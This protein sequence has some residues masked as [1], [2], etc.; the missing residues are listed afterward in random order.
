MSALSRAKGKAEVI[1]LILSPV[2]TGRQ[3]LIQWIKLWEGK[4][5]LKFPAEIPRAEIFRGSLAEIFRGSRAE[6]FRYSRAEIFRGSRA[7]QAVLSCITNRKQK[8][9]FIHKLYNSKKLTFDICLS[10]RKGKKD[11]RNNFK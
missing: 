9:T 2:D 11:K 5:K 7:R 8:H 6:I 1:F 10:K 3:M 4:N